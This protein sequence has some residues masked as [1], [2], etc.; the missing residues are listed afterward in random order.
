[1][2]IMVDK[3]NK[4]VELY[5]NVNLGELMEKLEELHPNGI[6]AGYTLLVEKE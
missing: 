1:M 4:T 5:E 6:W 2:K 3:I